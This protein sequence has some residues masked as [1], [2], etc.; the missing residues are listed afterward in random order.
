MSGV[1]IEICQLTDTK[2]C[3][4]LS[5]EKS[6]PDAKPSWFALRLFY[7]LIGRLL[8]IRGFCV[9]IVS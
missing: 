2:G 4:F 5:A 3:R 8:G 9:Y 7:V 6:I 1:R